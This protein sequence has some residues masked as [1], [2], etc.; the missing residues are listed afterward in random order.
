METKNIQPALSVV[1]SLQG[2][3]RLLQANRNLDSYTNNINGTHREKLSFTQFSKR[4]YCNRSLAASGL[5]HMLERGDLS[6]RQKMNGCS[7]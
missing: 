1:V 4:I 7:F 2:L 3:S 5:F 6:N